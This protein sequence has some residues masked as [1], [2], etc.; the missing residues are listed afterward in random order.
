[1]EELAVGTGTDLVNGL[2]QSVNLPSL[3][4]F[5]CPWHTHRGVEIDEDGA[6]DIFAAAGLGE[7]SLEGALLANVFGIRVGTTISLEAVLEQIP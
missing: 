5:L 6:G 2:Q 4:L 1:M 7:E 3:L